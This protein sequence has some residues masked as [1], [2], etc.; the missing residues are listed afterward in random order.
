[1]SEELAARVWLRMREV[2]LE[3]HDRR[4]EVAD[5][6]GMSF[7]RTKALRRIARG[8]LT[9]RELTD[10]LVTDRPYTTVIVDDLERRGLVTRTEHPEDR[11]RKIVAVTPA[12]AAAAERANRVLAQPPDPLRTLDPAD[13]AALHE[14]L[15]KL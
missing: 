8:P 6:L 11:R 4:K 3:Q 12:G 15:G 10:E 13:L 5:T 14:I 1:M 7:I 2:V 9:M